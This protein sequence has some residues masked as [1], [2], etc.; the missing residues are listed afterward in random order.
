MLSP[1]PAGPTTIDAREA[2]L[3]DATATTSLFELQVRL[4]RR[5]ETMW[6][7]ADKRMK[8][9][10]RHYKGEPDRKIANV[11]QTLYTGQYVYIDWAP[12]WTSAADR[13]ATD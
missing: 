2:L 6:Q 4:L 11:S 5:K 7:D 1:H 3:T 8:T 13:F 12:M 9:A 10:K